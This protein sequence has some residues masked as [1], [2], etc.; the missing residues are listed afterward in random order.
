[1]SKFINY[2]NNNLSPLA[3][4]EILYNLLLEMVTH[5]P[6]IQ[7]STHVGPLPQGTNKFSIPV[8]NNPIVQTTFGG[9]PQDLLANTIEGVIDNYSQV[10][11]AS[12][13]ILTDIPMQQ[14][15]D[16][17]LKPAVRALALNIET[18]AS[19][20][21]GRSPYQYST[22]SPTSFAFGDVINGMTA[23]NS[24]GFDSSTHPLYFTLSL[25]HAKTF[26]EL[27][28]V[29][30]HTS[31]LTQEALRTGAI[32]QTLGFEFTRSNSIPIKTKGNV[33]TSLWTI[34]NLY[35]GGLTAGSSTVTLY[36]T[37]NT[38]PVVGDS[39]YIPLA[40]SWHY[41]KTVTSPAASYRTVTIDPPLQSNSLLND[42]VQVLDY[43]GNRSYA[44]TKTSLVF[45]SMVPPVVGQE[46]G[47]GLMS[48]ITDPGTGLSLRM[49]EYYDN[50]TGKKVLRFDV[51]FGMVLV[52]PSIQIIGA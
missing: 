1:M 21:L 19:E 17:H 25:G 38:T 13:S 20:M 15:L 33:T 34:S 50:S 37:T 48:T 18:K 47:G 16:F 27:D 43:G 42:S 31:L 44:Y 11:L 6:I 2:F 29:T 41:I 36:S 10:S 40:N 46:Y 30:G 28:R 51:H 7:R 26:L 5:T 39:I 12:S 4:K 22:I 9:P 35:S 14:L 45:A 49:G 32:G 23:L 52:Q 24:L 8:P 3:L